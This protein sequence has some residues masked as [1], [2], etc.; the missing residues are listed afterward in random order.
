MVKIKYEQILAL[1]KILISLIE[2]QKSKSS[3]KAKLKINK[4]ESQVSFPNI[5]GTNR[6]ACLI[7]NRRNEF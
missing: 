7:Q 4:K 2:N 3:N 1:I 6:M 5:W